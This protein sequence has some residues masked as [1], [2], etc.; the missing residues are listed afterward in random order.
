MISCAE[1]QPL[2]AGPSGEVWDLS[3]A[4][5]REA[6]ANTDTGEEAESSSELRVIHDLKSRAVFKK[7]LDVLVASC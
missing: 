3:R 4:A 2:R 7:G 1:N 6:R 5:A